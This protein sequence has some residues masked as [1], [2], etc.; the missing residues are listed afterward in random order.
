MNLCKNR[1]RT[2]QMRDRKL[3]VTEN[4]LI[5][6]ASKMIAIKDIRQKLNIYN[7]VDKKKTNA[8]THNVD[9][10]E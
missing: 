10:Q 7:E 8:H 9:T 1:N 5:V 3:R 2:H 6:T 4:E